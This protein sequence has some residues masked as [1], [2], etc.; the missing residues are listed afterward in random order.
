MR[1]LDAKY[2]PWPKLYLEY[3]PRGSLDDQEHISVGEGIQI[4]DQLLSALVY[5]HGRNPP[6]VHRDIKSANILVQ[7]R[8]VGNIHVKFGDFG[9]AREERESGNWKTICGTWKY[10]APEILEKKKYLSSGGNKRL[11]YTAAVDIWS[12]GVVMFRLLC[13]LPRYKTEYKDGGNLWCKKILKKLQDDLEESPNEVIQFLS[14]TML[15]LQPELRG[16]A[17]ACHGATLFLSG[18]TGDIYQAPA[19]ASYAEDQE[20]TVRPVKHDNCEEPQIDSDE[21]QR[22]IRSDNPSPTVRG[23]RAVPVSK[24]SASEGRRTKR[25]RHSSLAANGPSRGQEEEL[26]QEMEPLD[27]DVHQN[28][29]HYIVAGGPDHIGYLINTLPGQASG[30]RS[31]GAGGRSCSQEGQ[32]AEDASDEERVAAALLLAMRNEEDPWEVQGRESYSSLLWR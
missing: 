3:M 18:A 19:P 16:S 23:K 4:L 12:L 31:S 13:G 8:H 15:V 1:L 11:K 27:H 17:Q 2:D 21:V 22:Y 6:I 28:S 9:L 10:A 25:S 30:G 5:L 29:E 26:G 20:A 24:A 14:T 32:I 7:S